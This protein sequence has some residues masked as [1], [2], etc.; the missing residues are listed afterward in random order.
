M[1]QIRRKGPNRYQILVYHGRDVQGK[2]I[3]Q[4]ET[5]YG[6]LSQARARAAELEVAKRRYGPKQAAKT[7]GEYLLDWLEKIKGTVS[8]RTHETYTWHVK[9]LIPIIGHLQLYGLNSF[10]LQEGLNQLK[11]K[12]K[13]AK[14]IYGTLKTAFRQAVAW[15]L[16]NTDPTAGLRA[17]RVPREEKK[18]LTPEELKRLLDAAENYKHH[19]I[20]R[21]LAV[22]G[23]RLGE[24]LGLMWKD[25]DLDKGTV[26]IKRAVNVRKRKIKEDTKTAASER[27]LKLDEKTLELLRNHKQREGKSKVSPLR[28]DNTLIF[29]APDGRPVREEAVRRTLARALKKAGIDHIRVHDLRHTAGSLLLE[30][31][32]SF[33]TVAAFLGHSSPA[34]T[35]AVYAHAVRKGTNVIEMLNSQPVCQPKAKKPKKD[36]A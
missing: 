14:G 16:L 29:A 21:L 10:D 33:P 6:T 15:G 28:R 2:R 3:I 8:E 4:Y 27:T 5:F 34:T 11:V 13:T 19:L 32:Y 24:V 1:A 17:P 25:V 30:A 18:V 12:P 22:T 20:I 9:K 7:V 35:A 23:M 36:K 26:T 31:G